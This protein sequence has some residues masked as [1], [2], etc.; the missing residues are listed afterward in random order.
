[1]NDPPTTS[2]D[3]ATRSL[4]LEP[5]SRSQPVLTWILK[6][7]KGIDKWRAKEQR[8]LADLAA[9]TYR[10]KLLRI[11]MVVVVAAREGR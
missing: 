11:V 2:L 7:K 5:L 4:S 1:M 6:G 9:V 8:N 10:N 3:R